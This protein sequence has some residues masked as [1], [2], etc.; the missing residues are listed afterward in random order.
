MFDAEARVLKRAA[1]FSRLNTI[2][3][4]FATNDF[5]ELILNWACHALSVGVRWF[6]LVACDTTLHSRL[7]AGQFSKH[8]L[9]LPRL[10][11]GNVT[12]TKLNIIGE[13]QIF[14]LS[15]AQAGLV[16]F[17]RATLLEHSE[18]DASRP[19]AAVLERGYSIVHSDA[20]A[21][22]IK[23]PYATRSNH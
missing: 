5:L 4:V 11:D 15:G 7:Q 17:E 10:R 1:R 3:L 14:G 22:W 2:A 16:D 21:L 18:V 20:D 19:T 8:A 9:L 23:D 12:L 13:R 6:V